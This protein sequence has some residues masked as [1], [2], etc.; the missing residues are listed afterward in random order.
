[1]PWNRLRLLI[2]GYGEQLDR[3]TGSH[4]GVVRYRAIH[5]AVYEAGQ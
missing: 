1:M 2:S 3:R 4:L 5:T